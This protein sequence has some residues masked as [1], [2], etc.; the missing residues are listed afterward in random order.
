MIKDLK[1]K[2][3]FKWAVWQVKRLENTG[4]KN[5]HLDN[6]DGKF[7]VWQMMRY[8]SREQYHK[9]DELKKYIYSYRTRDASFGK[10]V[11][12]ANFNPKF[13]KDAGR[14]SIEDI[15]WSLNE[16]P[17]DR[18]FK[19]DPQPKSVP[20]VVPLGTMWTKT[21]PN[22]NVVMVS[23]EEYQEARAK[24]GLPPI[25]PG[26]YEPEIDNDGNRIDGTSK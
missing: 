2:L 25:T 9:W 5:F 1:E 6:P 10:D 13:S 19:N 7:T 18:P 11:T 4:E 24:A 23:D 3:A 22:G 21:L 20:V 14:P 17:T 16:A 8:T 15:N 26:S 12:R